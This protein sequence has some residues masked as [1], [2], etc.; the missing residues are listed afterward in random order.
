MEQPA[1]HDKYLTAIKTALIQEWDPI[2]VMAIG[3]PLDE[4]DAYA[5]QIVRMLMGNASIEDLYKH[6]R[7]LETEHIGLQGDPVATKR[8]STRLVEIASGIAM[9]S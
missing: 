6:L 8:F 3:G 9:N 1:I 7:W 4:Y 5:P 2:G